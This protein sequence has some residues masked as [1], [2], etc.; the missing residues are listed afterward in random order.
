[1]FLGRTV[2]SEQ[3]RLS[4]QFIE[5]LYW[6]LHRYAGANQEDGGL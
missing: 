1:M 5:T 3:S 2:Y 6:V 4:A